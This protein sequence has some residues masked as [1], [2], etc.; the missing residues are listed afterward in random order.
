MSQTI[1]SFGETQ[2]KET[3]NSKFQENFFKLKSS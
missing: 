3:Q 2:A 1:K